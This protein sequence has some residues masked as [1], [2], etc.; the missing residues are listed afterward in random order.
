MSLQT[1]NLSGLA[2]IT[3]TNQIPMATPENF[4][5][6]YTYAQEKQPELIP[7]LVYKYG[8]GSIVGF[9]RAT[10]TGL[11]KTYQ[12]DYIQHAETG[13]LMKSFTGVTISGN[14]F[15]FP[16]AHGLEVGRVVRFYDDGV[17]YQGFVSAIVSTTVATILSDTDDSWPAGPVDIAVDFSSRFKKGD[18]AFELGTQHGIDTYKN[19]SHIY[20]HTQ[21]TTN[22]DLGQ[23]IWI[24]TGNGPQWW[25]HEMARESAKFDNITELTAVFHR[26]A[27]DTSDSATAG[28]PQGMYGVKQI[29][30]DRG[31]V[32]NDY[33]EDLDDLSDIAFRLKQQGDCRELN[34][35][36]NHQQMAK[37]RILAAGLNS[38]FLNGNHYGSFK[39]SKDMFLN[40][41]FVGVKVDGVQFNFVSWGALDD[42]TLTGITGSNNGGISFL[43]IPCGNTK[44]TMDGKGKSVSYMEMLFR[45]TQYGVRQKETKFFGKF[46]TPIKADKSYVDWLSEG[47][48]LLA[49]A[50]NFFAGGSYDLSSASI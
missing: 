47:T 12:S 14:N 17:E 37:F 9:M 36:C 31:N 46:G 34:I 24:K 49:A 1:N 23:R 19:Y 44:V 20:K 35:W 5:D 29:I 11:K 30:E 25:S 27:T 18:D 33:I 32:F 3:D 40:L 45:Q 4:V 39:N 28:N 26:R 6:L 16:S 41:D 43:G 8:K 22:S 38:A 48:V 10:S 15:T 21:D 7:D 2:V 42:P 13:R 50:N